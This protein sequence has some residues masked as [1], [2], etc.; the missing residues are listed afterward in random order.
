MV[1]PHCLIF[2]VCFVFEKAR[3][4]MKR[5]GKQ[6]EPKKG[7]FEIVMH[8]ITNIFMIEIYNLHVKFCKCSKCSKTKLWVGLLGL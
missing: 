5:K 3:I 6:M 1:T 4:E 7:K 2:F 8:L